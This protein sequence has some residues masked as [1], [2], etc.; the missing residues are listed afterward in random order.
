LELEWELMSVPEF[1]RQL[2]RQYA[3][4]LGSSKK[5]WAPGKPGIVKE[6]VPPGYDHRAHRGPWPLSVDHLEVF[7]GRDAHIH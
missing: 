7:L 4:D 2:R 3:K 6:L 1:A 5:G